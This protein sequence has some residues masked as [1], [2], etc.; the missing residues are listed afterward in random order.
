MRLLLVLLLAVPIHLSAQFRELAATDDG[1]HLY[2]SSTL[3]FPGMPVGYFPESRIYRVTPEGTEVFAERG[4]LAPTGQASSG[5]G[6]RMP[7]VSSDGQIVGFTLQGICEQQNPCVYVQ[8]RAEV[9]GRRN[10]VL[11]PGSLQMSRNGRWALLTSAP[12]P[13]DATAEATLIDLETG[14][15]TNVPSPPLRTFAIAS[16]GTV[17]GT[18]PLAGTP[19][20]TAAGLWRDG[21]FTPVSLSGP[22]SIWSISDNAKFLLY[23]QLLLT[24]EGPQPRLLARNI[25]TGGDIVLFEPQRYGQLVYPMGLSQDGQWVLFRVAEG[26]P[27]GPAF[28]GST[29]TGEVWPLPLSEGE[30]VSEGTLSGWGNAAFLVTTTGRIARIDLAAGKPLGT[31]TLV[32]ATPYVSGLIRGAPGSLVRLEGTLPQFAAHLEKSVLLNE[33]PLP[34]IFADLNTV[35]VQVPWEQPVG[36]AWLRLEV[37][38]ESPFQQ[39]DRIM[40]SEVAPQLEPLAAGET[41]LFPF[42]MVRG[43]FSGLLTTTPKPG[44]VIH[45]Y[46]TGIGPVASPPRTGEPAPTDIL[47]PT[48]TETVC[49]F[50]PFT[51]DAETLFSGL[52][53]GFIGVYQITLRMPEEPVSGPLTG[54]RC[55]FGAGTTISFHRLGSP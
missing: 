29:A 1:R 37:P 53:P 20:P 6:A 15:R 51:T 12:G 30:L 36:S 38:S 24:P 28:I 18:R 14:V 21:Q 44:E 4:T 25:S 55:R 31:T 47:F 23:T 48:L 27:E 32:P 46:A 42:K 11:G 16:D 3:I 19:G 52:A 45:I 9:R 49:R 35:G 33:Q 50:E 22:V 41:S 54:G 8:A 5:D 39:V 43:D 40:V 17:V 13:P 7:Q 26:R 10:A 2:F 34:I